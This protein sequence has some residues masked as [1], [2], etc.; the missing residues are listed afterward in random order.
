MWSN[1]RKENPPQ[2]INAALF[3]VY[4][5]EKR[6]G[7]EEQH[8]TIPDEWALLFGVEGRN[9]IQRLKAEVRKKSGYK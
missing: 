9:K 6:N 4:G 3:H 2:L 5:G 7:N 8:G 1:L